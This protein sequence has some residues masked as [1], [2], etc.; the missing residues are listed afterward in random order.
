M[1]NKNEAK[2]DRKRQRKDMVMEDLHLFMK[3]YL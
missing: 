3:T 2:L 1:P